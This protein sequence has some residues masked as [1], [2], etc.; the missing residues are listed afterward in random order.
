[1]AS[2]VP[3]L[4]ETFC[5][6]SADFLSCVSSATFQSVH[7]AGP[8]VARPKGSGVLPQARSMFLPERMGLL[9]LA[10]IPGRARFINKA[11][12]PLVVS[13]F[14]FVKGL[15]VFISVLL[16]FIELGLLYEDYH[17]FQ[18]ADYEF[19]RMFLRSFSLL[20]DFNYLD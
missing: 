15:G 12:C 20:P 16:V 3:H 7:F 2:V 9:V 10:G 4:C 13:W 11:R 14:L 1:M 8:S 18:L 17:V 19:G 5:C 6:S